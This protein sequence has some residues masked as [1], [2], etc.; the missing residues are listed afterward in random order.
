M[1]LC[2]FPTLFNNCIILDIW[3]AFNSGKATLIPTESWVD[4]DCI[5]SV[6]AKGDLDDYCNL[7]ILIFAKIVNLLSTTRGLKGRA[8][9]TSLKSSLYSLWEE[10]Q[11]WRLQRPREAY[12]LL[13]DTEPSKPFPEVLYSRSSPSES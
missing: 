3:A 5:H 13:R 8:R 1:Q 10:M 7:A 4:D 11:D 12:P 6:Y 2:A 9:A